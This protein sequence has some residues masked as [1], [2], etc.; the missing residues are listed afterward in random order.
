MSSLFGALTVAVGGLTA[1]SDALGNI[2]DNLSNSQTT[3]FKSIGTNFESLVTS[4]TLTDNEPGGVRATPAYQN[5]VQGN[6]VQSSIGT[7]LA[8]SGQGFFPVETA[9]QN[10]DGTTSLSSNTLYTREGDFTLNNKGFLVNSSGYY[11]T[12]YSVAANGTVDKTAT[13]PIQIQSLINSPVA[14]TEATY[15]ANLPAS[16]ATAFTSSASTINIFDGQG[17]THPMTF[18]WVKTGTNTWNLQVG[19]TNGASGSNYAATIPFTFNGTT[20]VGTIESITG[21]T[22]YTVPSGTAADV[23][24]DLNFSGAGGAQDVTLNFGDY[25]TATGLTQF[26]GTDVSVSSFSQD[27]LPQG[28]FSSLSIDSGGN[29]AINYSNGS[30]RIVDQIPIATFNAPNALQ[31]IT[32]N[33]YQQTLASGTATLSAAGT[34]GAGSI[35]TGSLESSNVD[36]ATQFTAMIEA[37]QIYSANA[38]T[39][40]TVDNML[41][42]IINTIQ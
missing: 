30:T 13:N 29:V 21:G 28:S 34:D 26:A 10:A 31:R 19:V 7:Y 11:L 27:G 3:G 20:D 4:S 5:D 14:T 37:Q 9:T 40:T 36:I 1:Q 2:S 25:N 17:N 35:A 18:T 42:T 33:A 12:G 15:V 39:I 41:N 23:T 6:L 22:G 16:A 24:L 38:K 32:G 8:I